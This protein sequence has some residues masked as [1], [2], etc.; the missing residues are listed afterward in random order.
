MGAPANF[1][2]GHHVMKLY[3]S[4]TSLASSVATF[5]ARG[6]RRGDPAVMISAARRFDLV[7]RYLRSGGFG[8]ATDVVHKIRF[9]DAEALLAQILGTEALN[10][11]HIRRVF[12]DLL[13]AVRRGREHATIWAYGDTVDLL[14]KRRNHAASTCLEEIANSLRSKHE[15]IAMLC[16]YSV[17]NFD[18]YEQANQLRSVCAQHTH[19]IPAYGFTDRLC[20]RAALEPVAMLQQRARASGCEREREPPS[21]ARETLERANTIYLI[22]DEECVRRSLGRLLAQLMLPVR[23]YASAEE[24]L[25]QTDAAARGCLIVDVHLAGMKGPELQNL[26]GA[27]R[28]SLPVIAISG[29]LDPQVESEALRQGARVFLS[30]PLD[31]QTLFDVIRR[32]LAGIDEAEGNLTMRPTGSV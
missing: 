12:D 16:G 32:A 2:A 14:C 25:A 19:V 3:E 20:E 8:L 23:T 27:A 17:E 13:T 31:A 11:V 22:D 24:F 26:L 6:L 21:P 10:L 9:M 4:E 30:K 15:P 28:W 5:F 18:E 7:R 1:A 29:S